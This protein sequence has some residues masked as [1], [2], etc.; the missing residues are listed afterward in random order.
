MITVFISPL[1]IQR[2]EIEKELVSKVPLSLSI[3]LVFF[4][5]SAG[6][7]GVDCNTLLVS[8]ECIGNFLFGMAPRCNETISC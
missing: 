1:D 6:I 5:I 2:V 3:F 8:T 4:L 7:A